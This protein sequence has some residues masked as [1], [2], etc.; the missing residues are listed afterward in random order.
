LQTISVCHRD[1]FGKIEKNVF[2]VIGGQPNAT[3]MTRVKI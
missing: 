3:T 2:S 1:G